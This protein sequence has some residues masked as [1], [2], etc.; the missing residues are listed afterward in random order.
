MLAKKSIRWRCVPIVHAFSKN[1]SNH[2]IRWP[3]LC[4]YTAYTIF[5][6]RTYYKHHSATVNIRGS[7]ITKKNYIFLEFCFNR[8]VT[9]S[10]DMSLDIWQKRNSLVH[11]LLDYS[12]LN[13]S[14]D[15]KTCTP[16][17]FSVLNLSQMR[18]YVRLEIEKHCQTHKLSSPQFAAY[19]NRINCWIPYNR[20]IIIVPVTIPSHAKWYHTEE[21]WFAKS[22]ETVP[23]ALHTCSQY[24]CPLPHSS[25][26]V[27]SLHTL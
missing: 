20:S 8:L 17:L 19:V 26:S 23:L 25:F 1:A 12:R 3:I 24:L 27:I 4:I 18:G 10:F 9:L 2:R 6:L 22:R 5:V 7:S 14:I 15:V 21:T 11:S 16:I 13:K